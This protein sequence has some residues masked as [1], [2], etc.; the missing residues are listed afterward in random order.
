M[1]TRFPL[2]S[3][4]TCRRGNPALLPAAG[5]RAVSRAL[6]FTLVALLF[7]GCGG[8]DNS[9]KPPANAPP[10]VLSI[11]FPKPRVLTHMS[12]NAFASARD[13]DDPILLYSWS[14]TRGTFPLGYNWFSVN[15]FSP[16]DPGLDSLTVHVNDSHQTVSLSVPV[17]VHSVD[18]PS[19]LTA[20]VGTSIADL[21]WTPSRDE[22]SDST[23]R[24][25]EL[26][27]A[28]RTFASIPPDSVLAY[29]IAGPITESSFRASELVRGT[30]YYFRVGALRA[31]EGR[32]ERSPLTAEIDL[33][34]RAEWTWQLQEVRNP[35]GG[36]AIDLSSGEVLAL[37]PAEASGL[38]RRDLYFGTS[39]P[40]DGP[41]PATNPAA[42]RIK[43]VSLLRNRNAAWASRRVQLKRLGSDWSVST[44]S[45]DGW[46]EEADLQ[47]GAVYAAKTPEGNFAKILVADLPVAISPY[48]QLTVKWAF[49]SIRDYPRF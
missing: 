34:P 28:T 32:E 18:P 40:L 13:T 7:A 5:R 19:A 27:A 1:M 48:R 11:T 45:D 4:P 43:S 22:A 26:Y 24:G 2:D 42:P 47:Q 6:L 20:S 41:G 25:Y 29:R 12:V 33:G 23:W 38:S 21:R 30:I 16:D 3:A 15:W 44:V 17:Q 46:G 8:G 14:A 37:D 9:T 49:Q 10:Q 31:W 35:A 36:L 39:D